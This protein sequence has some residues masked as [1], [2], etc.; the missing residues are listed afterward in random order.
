[1][2]DYLL[3]AG[4]IQSSCVKYTVIAHGAIHEQVENI[5]TSESFLAVDKEKKYVRYDYVESKVDENG[6]ESVSGIRHLQRDT[7]FYFG[8]G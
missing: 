1:M 8:Q 2:G 5:E 3:D 6:N 7:K 4:A